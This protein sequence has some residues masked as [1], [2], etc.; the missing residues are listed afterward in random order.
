VYRIR[1]REQALFEH[2]LR[3]S[4][5]A[6]LTITFALGFAGT[7]H[8]AF[9]GQNGKIVFR[10]NR[11]GNADLYTMNPDGSSRV[12]LT[13]NPAE[14]VDPRWSPDGTQIAF[15]SNRTGAYE[16]Y[17]MD[18]AGTNVRQLTSLGANSRRPSWTADGRILFQSD[19]GGNR[20]V[21]AINA[22]G[23][24]LTNLTHSPSDD[25][26][27]AA[28]PHGG[29]VVFTSDR[30]GDYHLYL[31]NG[32]AP[33][34]QVTSG[35]GEDFE[36]NWSPSGNDL[37]FVRFDSTFSTSD[38][39]IAR[40][41]GDVVQLTSTPNRIEFE[42]A[43]SP[44]GTKI[45]FH[46]CSDLGGPA[47]HCAN[48]VVNADGTGETEVTK[49][50]TAPFVDDFSS[51]PLDDFWTTQLVGGGTTIAQANGRLEIGLPSSTTLDPGSGFANPSVFSK[52]NLRGDF[53][54]Q[55]DYD[56]V[57]WPSPDQVNPLFN[58]G[59]FVNGNWVS[60]DGMFLSRWGL[61]SNFDDGQPAAFVPNV[62]ARGTLRLTRSGDM[63][64]ASYNV[65]GT[66]RVLQT[67]TGLV[68]DE[69]DAALSVFSNALP[70]SH[71]DVLV[72]YDNFRV[73][74]GTF[75]CPTWWDDNAPDWQ[76][77]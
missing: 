29:K 31:M 51:T 49:T 61:S 70:G 27:A 62:P 30:G 15:A 53:D 52:C 3:R 24:G 40:P 76:A 37:V 69:S 12:Q 23:S 19:L 45:V 7:V 74:S 16:I 2:T 39:Y 63:L 68:A 67:R 9:P 5:L 47:Q 21:Y 11:S 65:D 22:D 54:M 60:A 34:R 72:A 77:Q 32:N 10:S 36:A 43:W 28:S 41:N 18:A 64:T 20:D 25:A 33:V 13:T 14:D 59:N 56:L 50:F 35:N 66:W 44:D 57:Q 75:S 73:N 6:L 26:Y 48:Y 38:L 1:S 4:V 42:P 17:T 58:E 55:V 46:A 71:G 8:A